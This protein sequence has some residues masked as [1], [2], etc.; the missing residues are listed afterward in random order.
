MTL[1]RA[2]KDPDDLS[3][4]IAAQMAKIDQRIADA[5][6][7]ERAAAQALD[8]AVRRRRQL[9]D[10]GWDRRPLDLATSAAYDEGRAA[11]YL[12][13]LRG[14]DDGAEGGVV[15]L[16][17][18]PGSGKTAAAARWASTRERPTR[19]LRAAEFFRSSRYDAAAIEAGALT[20]DAI[21]RTGALVLDDLGAEYAD[22][23]GNYRVDLD[24][25]I[26]RFYAGKR[27]LVITTNIRFG[28]ERAR[29]AAGDEHKGAET[30]EGRYG[31]RVADRLR[32]CGRWVASS[33]SSM[34]RA[35]R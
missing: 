2:N 30:F 7:E 18:V 32:E 12:A 6:P 11:S 14:L 31:A 27:T 35:G 28:T 3:A 19:F 21:L 5:S 25:L 33:S 13:A 26:D 17:G 9:E 23:H 34:R 20:R 22:A 15:V 29:D 16:T 4:L 8:R 24:E 1:T 10:L